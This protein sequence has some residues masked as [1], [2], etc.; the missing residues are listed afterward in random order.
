MSFS[1]WLRNWKRSIERRWALHQT[2]PRKSSVR[3]SAARLRL[4]SLEDR[5]LLSTYYVTSTADDGSPGTL[6]DAINQVNQGLY[7]EIDFNIGAVGSAQT[8]YVGDSGLGGLP[9][10]QASGVYI[11]GLSQGG[12]GNTFALSIELQGTYAGATSGLTLG[13]SNCTVSG[14]IIDNFQGSGIVDY[15]HNNLIGGEAVAGNVLSENG[16]VGLECG[17]GDLA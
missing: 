4:E 5:Y 13:Q 16:Q 2:L 8:I 3:Q 7:N 15:G 6:R 17:S 1:S 14:L 9:N 12:S 10:L 11:N